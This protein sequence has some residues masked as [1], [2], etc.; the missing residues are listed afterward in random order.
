M[1]NAGGKGADSFLHLVENPYKTTDSHSWSQTTP[2]ESGSTIV[3]IYWGK[4]SVEECNCTVQTHV[5]HVLTVLRLASIP[6]ELAIPIGLAS[7]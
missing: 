5:V 6:E 2:V 3:H 4:K 7:I 1:S